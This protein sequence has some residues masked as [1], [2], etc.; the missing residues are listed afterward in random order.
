MIPTV[1]YCRAVVARTQCIFSF[2]RK[3]TQN[4]PSYLA[5]LLSREMVT[6]VFRWFSNAPSLATD[7]IDPSH[8]SVILL[9]ELLCHSCHPRRFPSPIRLVVF[10]LRFLFPIRSSFFTSFY[11][12][13]CPPR[14]TSVALA[15]ISLILFLF[16]SLILF[17][18]PHRRHLGRRTERLFPLWGNG[19]SFR[20]LR[21]IPRY[22][23]MRHF[24]V[25]LYHRF[26]TSFKRFRVPCKRYKTFSLGI[27]LSYSST[28]DSRH[29][30]DRTL[31]YIH[32]YISFTRADDYI[33]IYTYACSDALFENKYIKF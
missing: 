30:T 24:S 8:S 32:T 27:Y 15:G 9:A 28:V 22:S 1:R 26:R 11:G 3:A 29:D 17:F 6:S 31:M 10:F 16:P 13:R 33:I 21:S 7:F 19:I 25:A 18:I 23:F 5:T 12:S 14:S 4:P 20:H 2:S